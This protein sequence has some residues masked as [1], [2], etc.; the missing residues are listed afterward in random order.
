MLRT[1]EVCIS[2]PAEMLAVIDVRRMDVPRSRYI[3]RILERSLSS[4]EAVAPAP[5]QV[6]TAPALT[7]EVSEH[8]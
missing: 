3:R 7:K 8:V 5:Q 1:K 6:D 2:I 4:Q